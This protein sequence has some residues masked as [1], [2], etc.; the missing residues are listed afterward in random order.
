MYLSFE[1]F[2]LFLWEYFS[3]IPNRST[4]PKDWALIFMLPLLHIVD[5]N[6]EIGSESL[7]FFY[8]GTYRDIRKLLCLKSLAC[9]NQ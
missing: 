1:Y 8:R 7:I 4:L 9:L 3:R 5:G 6:S 2:G